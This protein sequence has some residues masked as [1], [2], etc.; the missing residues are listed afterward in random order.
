MRSKFAD[1]LA[2]NMQKL[3]IQSIE[4]HATA[5]LQDYEKDQLDAFKLQLER[6][7][8]LSKNKHN[9]LRGIHDRAMRPA[10][11]ETA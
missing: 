1:G 4:Q 7:Q 11:Q 10:K 8:P 5:P 2:V 6:G 3:I 9:I